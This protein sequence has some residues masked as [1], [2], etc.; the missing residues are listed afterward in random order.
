MLGSTA[1]LY[2][3]MKIIL[4]DGFKKHYSKITDFNSYKKIL[5]TP[6]RKS[7]RINTLKTTAEKIIETL[8]DEWTLSKIPW[9]EDGYFI[10]HKKK[11][12]ED[13]EK[14]EKQYKRVKLLEEDFEYRS[15]NEDSKSSIGNIPEHN[16]GMFY[17]QEAASMVSAQILNPKPG[18][19]VLDLCASPGSKTT[20][21]AQM[22][23]NTGKITAL[24]IR[25]DRIAILN[26]NIMRMGITNCEILQK[27]G[28]QIKDVLFDK[29]LVDAPCSGTGTMRTQ[30]EIDRWN[31][32]VPKRM[33]NEQKSLLHS[34]FCV[35]KKGGTMVYSTCSLEPEENEEVIDWLLKRHKK[36]ELEEIKIIGIKKSEPILKYEGNKFD[37]QISKCL[38]IMPQ[39]NNTSGFFV[40]KILKKW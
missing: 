39:D 23:Q 31:L 5:G 15:K 18:E 38:R 26:R 37:K 3:T 30:E 17:V 14:F 32:V 33:S 24:D 1:V 27:P 8:K 20:Q 28:Q 25:T 35:L 21:M 13:N 19:K 36:T 10:E 6:L 4:P 34:A 29:I 11:E 22:M 9:A 16:T 12:R 2:R 40:A 7:I